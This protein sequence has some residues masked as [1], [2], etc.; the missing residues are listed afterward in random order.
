L[1]D[2]AHPILP[3]MAQGAAMAIEDA[4]VLAARL[5]ETPD[6]I[7][8]AFRRYEADRTSRIAAVQNTSHRNG[9]I[10]RFSGPAALA[11]DTALRLMSTERLMAR[12]DWLYGYRAQ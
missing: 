12:Y 8:Q 7:G 6:D 5:G 10:F 9:T 1:G 11:R 2:A 4:A 3:H